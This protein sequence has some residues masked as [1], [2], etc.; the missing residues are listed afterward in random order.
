MKTKVFAAALAAIMLTASLT[1][2]GSKG[3]NNGANGAADG[4]EIN[5]CLASEPGTLDPA[6]NSSVDGATLCAH[7]FSGLAKWEKNEQ[8][9]LEIVPDLATELSEGVQNADGTVT[10]TYTLRDG[11]KWSDGKDVTAHDFEFAWNRACSTALAADYGYMFEVVKGYEDIWA[12]DDAGNYVNADAKLA[13]TAKDDKTLEVTLN[14]EVSYWNELLAFPSYFPVRE[15]VVSNESWATDPSTYVCNGPYTMDSWEHNSVITLVKNDNYIDADKITMGAINFYLSDDANNMLTNFRN[16]DWQLID[17]VPT[18]EIASLKS[19]Y[20]DNFVVTGQLGTYYI[21]WNINYDLLPASCTLT[22]AEKE[23]AEAEVRNALSLIIDRNYLVDNVSQGGQVPAS[24]FVAMGLTEPDGSQFYQNAGGNSFPGYYD[25]SADAYQNNWNTAIETLKKYYTYDEA[26]GKFT[27]FPSM[28]YLYN[29]SEGHKAIAEN[30]Q[31]I[32]ASIGLDMSLENQEWATFLETRK[33]GDFTVARNG[34]L[35]DYNDPISFLDM[36]TTASGNNDVQYGKGANAD[37]K[38]Y[39]IDCTD[40]GVD[41][42][43]ENGTWAETYDALMGIIKTTTDNTTRYKLMHKA[44]D[45]LMQTGCLTPIYYYTDLYM[46][47]SSVKGFFSN[48]LGYKYFM[49]CTIED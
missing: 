15:D 8:G 45:I 11:A 22:G 32:F 31:G 44:E 28:T 21:S 46:I 34:W 33:S 7:M 1:S 42:K 23:A 20:P 18:N 49:Y 39:S 14:N 6:L 27:D 35:A 29:T 9:M 25:V 2:C 26:S 16:H 43:V 12:T 17:D 36:W 40:C 41:L 48:P 24:S 3:G 4:Q 30:I 37:L 5:V 47:D 13:V 10:Y 19:Q 38:A